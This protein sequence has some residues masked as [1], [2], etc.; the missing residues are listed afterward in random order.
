M[1]STNSVIGIKMMGQLAEDTF[2]AAM[3]RNYPNQDAEAGAANM[4]EVWQEYL[5][6]PS[7]LPFKTVTVDGLTK[8]LIELFLMKVWQCAD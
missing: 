3:Q 4:L 5:E 6:D 1:P 2:L 8:V 7:W